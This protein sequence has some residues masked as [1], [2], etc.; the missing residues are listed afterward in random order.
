M[1]GSKEILL[2]DKVIKFEEGVRLEPYYD[3]LGYPTIG[4]GEL[5][6]KKGDPLPNIKWTQEQALSAL[7]NKLKIALTEMSKDKVLKPVWESLEKDFD[8]K[9]ILISMWYQLGIKRLSGFTN[10]LKA[11][12]AEDWVRASE[13]MLDSDAARVSMNRWKRQSKA[14][15]T[16]DVISSY[17]L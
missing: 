7:E 5:I 6:G 17:N 3:T 11:I 12:V 4:F 16:G 13:E 9:A 8:R 15:L 14:M 2:A 1:V 10:T